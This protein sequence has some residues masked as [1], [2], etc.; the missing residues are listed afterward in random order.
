MKKTLLK[1]PSAIYLIAFRRYS[2]ASF[3]EIDLQELTMLCDCSKK[4]AIVAC[5]DFKAEQ[6]E[7]REIFAAVEKKEEKLPVSIEPYALNQ[8]ATPYS[9]A[10]LAG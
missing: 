10:L 5:S 3:W 9:N 8:T 1:F 7:Q 4:E 2:K 6:V